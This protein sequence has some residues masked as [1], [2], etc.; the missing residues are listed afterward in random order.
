MDLQGRR[1]CFDAQTIER[2]GYQ[3]EQVGSA[4]G[5]W[6]ALIHPEDIDRL[7]RELN[8]VLEGNAPPHPVSYRIREADG[9]WTA[10]ALPTHQQRYS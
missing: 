5:D 2:L 7:I 4:L 1:A 3:H 8:Q 6:K 10:A 9:G